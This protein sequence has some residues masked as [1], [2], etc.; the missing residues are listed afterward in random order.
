MSLPTQ[1]CPNSRASFLRQVLGQGSF[2]KVFLAEHKS[3]KESYAIKVLNKAR[4]VQDDDIIAT[5]TER[6]VLT[7]GG[8]CPFLAQMHAGFQVCRKP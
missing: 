8:E 4:V 2:G 1:I 3:S 6:R 7:L 5:M